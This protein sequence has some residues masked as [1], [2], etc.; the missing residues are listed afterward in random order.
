MEQRAQVTMHSSTQRWHPWLSVN[1]LVR[2]EGS[3]LIFSTCLIVRIA[4]GTW[5]PTDSLAPPHTTR[6][7]GGPG[8]PG[9]EGSVF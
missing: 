1:W 3:G 5:K 6:C 4:K 8:G 7:L 9:A 2:L